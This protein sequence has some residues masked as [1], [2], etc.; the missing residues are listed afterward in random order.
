MPLVRLAIA[1]AAAGQNTRSRRLLSEATAREGYVPP[2]WVG[3]AY[4]YLGEK[5]TAFRYLRKANEQNDP[6]MGNL[7]V[8]P[9]VDPIRSD[10]GYLDLL[11]KADLSN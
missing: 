8:D 9:M 10:P 2:Y 3:I 5:D 4:L 11:K 6:S 1:Y 7:K